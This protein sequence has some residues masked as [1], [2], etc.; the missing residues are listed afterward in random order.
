MS[1]TS[2]GNVLLV[3]FGD[4]PG[5]DDRAYDALTELGELDSQGQISIE[6]ATVITRELDG[7]VTVKSQVGND[8]WA[9]TATGGLL[10][11][12][13]GVVGGPLGVLLGGWGGL[14]IGSLFD[15]DDVE[16][17]E[18]VLAAISKKIHPSRT[19]V[20]AEVT[21]QSPDVVDTA[22]A[23]LGG[24]VTRQPVAEVERELAAAESAERK[25]KIE[26]R[27]E[28]HQA[29]VAKQKEDAHAKV[30][31]LKK[32]VRRPKAGAAA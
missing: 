30:E 9:G 11:L 29:R 16:S 28:L 25:A 5:N 23:R 19:A 8:P 21:E 20:L 1:L 2:T 12:L 17:T 14:L 26:A 32:K 10:G 13:I 31:A 27:K 15:L 4:D 7:E 6:A 3:T 18:S 22:M 24:E